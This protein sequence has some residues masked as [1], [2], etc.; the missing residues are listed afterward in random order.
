MYDQR[1][2]GKIDVY[3]G[4]VIA[5]DDV[6]DTDAVTIRDLLAAERAATLVHHGSMETI[7]DSERQ[8]VLN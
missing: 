7:M 4:V 2:D 8:F 1:D 3:A 6:I 5:D